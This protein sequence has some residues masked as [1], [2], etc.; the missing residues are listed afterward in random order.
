MEYSPNTTSM[1]VSLQSGTE[2]EERYLEPT[3]MSSSSR[4][5]IWCAFQYGS[6][7]PL[8]LIRQRQLDERMR[9]N[10]RIGFNGVQCLNK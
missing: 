8:A 7:F 5:K 9:S 4:I 3:F 2:L 10:D 1:R 6:R